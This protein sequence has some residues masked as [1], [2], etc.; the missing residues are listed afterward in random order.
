MNDKETVMFRIVEIV[1]ECC[2]MR[3]DFNG[4][5]SVTYVYKENKIKKRIGSSNGSMQL[6]RSLRLT[7]LWTP[8][9]SFLRDSVLLTDNFIRRATSFRLQTYK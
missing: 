9:N 2:A 5:M 8:S 4:K 6:P 1:V 3:V 7:T